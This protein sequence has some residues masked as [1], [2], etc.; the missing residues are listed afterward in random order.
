M[1]NTDEGFLA[2]S[3]CLKNGCLIEIDAIEETSYKVKPKVKLTV[4][5]NG[6]RTVGKLFYSQDEKLTDVIK[7][8]YVEL[9][10]RLE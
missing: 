3:W 2:F 4:N 5:V 10:K 7:D 6:K 9:K 8:L 1:K